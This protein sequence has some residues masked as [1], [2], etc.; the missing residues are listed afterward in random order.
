MMELAT[1]LTVY[2]VVVVVVM[3]AF[4]YIFR[5]TLWSCMN[6]AIIFGLIVLIGIFPPN[7]LLSGERLPLVATYILILIFSP[8]FII[9]YALSKGLFDYQY[10]YI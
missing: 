4:Y 5:I 9:I 2:V 8:I 7:K 1:A 6:L 3:I 10:N